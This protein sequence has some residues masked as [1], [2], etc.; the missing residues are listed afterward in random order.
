MIDHSPC[1][2]GDIVEGEYLETLVLATFV[3]MDVERARC[4]LIREAAV[5]GLTVKSRGLEFL[6]GVQMSS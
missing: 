6:P 3:L 5:F 2:G 1:G 4:I